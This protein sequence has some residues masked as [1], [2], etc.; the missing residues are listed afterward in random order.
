LQHSTTVTL[1]VIPNTLT[2]TTVNDTDSAITYSAGWNYSTNRNDGDYNNDVHD[3]KTN[4]NYAQYTFNGTGIRYITETYSDESNVDIYI[5]GSYQTTVHCY[6]ATRQAQVV[7]YSNT[8]LAPGSHTIKIVKDNGTYALLDAFAYASATVPDFSISA[9]P[10]SVAVNPGQGGSYTVSVAATNGFNS[11]VNFM[12]SGL[13]SGATGVFNPASVTGSG[14][15]TLTIT[16]T[17]TLAAGT[18]QLSITGTSGT[19]VHTATPALIINS[20][21]WTLVNDSDANITYSAGWSYSSGRGDGDYDDDVHYTKTNADYA[22]YTFT[23]T[24]VE[25]VTETYSD[26]GNVDVYIDGVYQAT[27]DCVSSTRQAQVVMYLN[28]S[29]AYGSHTIEVVK[30]SGT[31]M[32]LDAFGFR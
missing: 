7:A 21:P 11:T 22:Q 14:T 13:P 17:N 23:G 26:E 28:T 15:S 6:S 25:Y 8:A 29:L 32:L 10:S 20:D 27:V 24:S 31:Y 16:T 18:N 19:L 9:S 4:G 5:D 12:V 30:S 3:T 2:W 1:I